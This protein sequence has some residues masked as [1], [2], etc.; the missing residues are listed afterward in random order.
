MTN[1]KPKSLNVKLPHDL[2]PVYS[3]FA[4]ISHTPSEVVIDLAQALPNQPEVRVKARVIMTPLS[5]KLL[6]NALQENIAKYEATFGEVKV[7]GQGNDL[8]REFFGG[9]RPPDME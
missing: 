6:R 8:T 9:V 5:A 3:N 7:P 4:M 1:K 2:E